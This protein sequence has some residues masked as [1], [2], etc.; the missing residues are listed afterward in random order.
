VKVAIH[1]LDIDELDELGIA[2]S[3]VGSLVM[4]AP[5]SRLAAAAPLPES[6]GG[7]ASTFASTPEVSAITESRL[8]R[9]IADSRVDSK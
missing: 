7:Y 4:A 2:A 8:V 9:T 6:P 5:A 1:F 3:L